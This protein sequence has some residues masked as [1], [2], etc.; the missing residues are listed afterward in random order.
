[1]HGAH[2]EGPSHAR[3]NAP[4]CKQW[5]RTDLGC[6]LDR[7]DALA[8]AVHYFTEQMDRDA[9]KA[10]QTH[11]QR[12]LDRQVEEFRRQ[13]LRLKGGGTRATLGRRRYG[14]GN[15]TPS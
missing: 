13:Y 2:E 11:Q 14:R 9:A 8:L 4:R 1:M 12:E 6:Y 3:G 7:L 10:A 5:D 15:T